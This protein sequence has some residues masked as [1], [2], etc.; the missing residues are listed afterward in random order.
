MKAAVDAAH[1]LGKKIAIHSY[2]PRGARDAV[3]RA[4]IRWKHAVTWRR[5]IAE[6]ARKKI[7][8]VPTIDHNRYYV[9]NAQML[10]IRGATGPLNDSS[11]AIW[12]R[13]KKHFAPGVRFAMGS[14]QCIP[15]S[16]KTLANWRGCQSR[17]DA[18]TALKQRR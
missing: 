14:T 12:K 4:Q 13:R 17:H 5:N 7:F 2:G 11:R 15:C 16:A 3:T 18:G 9:D 6:M 1:A 10:A 8:Y